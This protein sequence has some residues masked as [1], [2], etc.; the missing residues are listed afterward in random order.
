MP[1]PTPVTTPVVPTVAINTLALAHVPP[2]VASVRLV[3]KPT[4]T[5]PVPVIADGDEL[6]VTVVVA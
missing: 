4:H 2:T 3:V 6:T 5:T 1:A